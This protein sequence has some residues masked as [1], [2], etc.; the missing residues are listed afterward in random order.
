MRIDIRGNSQLTSPAIKEHARRRLQ[1]A[2]GRFQARILSVSV[3]CSDA[4]GPR[5]GRD[6]ICKI[7]ARLQGHHLLFIEEAGADLYAAIDRACERLGQAV[8]RDVER[9]QDRYRRAAPLF[10]WDNWGAVR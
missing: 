7:E 2:V 4:N 3:R 5:G 6:K 9:R 10:G 1:F 8:R